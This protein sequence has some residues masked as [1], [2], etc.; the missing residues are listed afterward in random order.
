MTSYRSE[1][2][3]LAAGLEVL[4]TLARSGIINIRSVK[5]VC[6]NKSEILASKRQSSDS[7]FHKTET[8]YDVKSTI[9]ELQ[10]MWCNNLDIKYAWLE[11]QAEK[12]DREPDKYER[13][14]IL[15]DGICDDIRAAATGI[16]GTRGSCGMRPS[17]TCVLFIRDV[18]VKK[19]MKEILTQQLID[20]DIQKYLMAKEKWTRKVL[21]S[22]N[23]KS[24]GTAFKRLPRSRQTTVTKACH[25][26][27]HTGGRYK[28]YYGG[29]KHCCRYGD[30]H[31][32][33]RHVITC[34][35]LD[36]SLHRT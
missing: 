12:L 1:V 30:A 36:A 5:C 32:D 11:G 8:D 34:N 6:D 26:L 7:I 13:L 4:D 9:H 23:W 15:A 2:G 18:K 28:Q 29:Q 33:W 31:E 10:A 25:N 3:G 24:Y 20:G 19:R 16:T 27:W 14:N 35:S 22:I 17:E 21:D